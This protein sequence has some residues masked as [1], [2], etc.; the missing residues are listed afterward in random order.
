MMS[1]PAACS[2]R[3][4]EEMAMVWLGLMRFRRSAIRGMVMVPWAIFGRTVIADGGCCNRAARK[5]GE[6]GFTDRYNFRRKFS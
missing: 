6:R 5:A 2:A 4:F 3:A 1:R